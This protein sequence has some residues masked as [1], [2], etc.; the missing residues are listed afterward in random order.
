[1]RT[2]LPLL[3]LAPA[4][5]PEN[6]VRAIPLDAIAVTTGDYDRME[7]CLSRQLVNH[8]LYEGFIVGATWD[9]TVDPD[10]M[11]LKVEGLLGIQD[12]LEE[13]GAVFVNS[14]TRGLG[15]WVYNGIEADDA[16][17]ADA[18]VIENV[19]TFVSGGGVLVVTDWAY[20]LVEAAWPDAIAFAGDEAVLDDAQR[21]GRGEVTARVL[22]PEISARLGADQLGIRYD[23][24]HWAVIDH[25]SDR[26]AVHLEGDI[27]WRASEAEGDVPREGVPLLVSFEEGLGQVVFATFHFRVQTPQVA[28]GLLL[29]VVEGLYS[30]VEPTDGGDTGA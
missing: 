9:P 20:D 7:E 10:D 16:L 5:R 26:V 27:T 12:E 6:E 3:L 30:G 1:M 28:D 8:Q 15:A 22:D 2:L 24:S 29:S 25:V 11:V 4:C 14:G 18:E 17:V 19:R 23:F 21:G 13:F